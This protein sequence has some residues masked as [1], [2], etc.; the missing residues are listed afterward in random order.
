VCHLIVCRWLALYV[1]LNSMQV[2][3]PVYAIA[4]CL[5]LITCAL[6]GHE[7]RLL[8]WDPVGTSS[9]TVT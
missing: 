5:H 7:L 3:G 6:P 8:T 1:P 2:I 4:T 9:N